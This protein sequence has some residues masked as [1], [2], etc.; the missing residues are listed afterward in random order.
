MPYYTVMVFLLFES[1]GAVVKRQIQDR[2]LAGLN[3]ASTKCCVF[4]QDTWSE[5]FIHI[6]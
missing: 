2:E 3:P 4:E 5:H 6:A 1:S